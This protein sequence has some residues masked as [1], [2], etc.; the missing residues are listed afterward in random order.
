MVRPPLHLTSSEMLL[1]P[2]PI[3]PLVL[4]VSLVP[5]HSRA[6]GFFGREVEKTNCSPFADSNKSTLRKDSHKGDLRNFAAEHAFVRKGRLSSHSSVVEIGGRCGDQTRTSFSI[7]TRVVERGNHPP[8][9]RR[10]FWSPAVGRS[11]TQV[12]TTENRTQ[13]RR[14]FDPDVLSSFARS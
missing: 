4:Q 5:I 2:N 3:F 11:P 10:A 13:D 9:L 12:D 6:R 7:R 14:G 1:R 8:K